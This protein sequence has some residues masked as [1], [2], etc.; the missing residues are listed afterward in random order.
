MT[1]CAL[2]NCTQV[3]L[4]AV[5]KR[6]EMAAE[7]QTETVELSKEVRRRRHSSFPV[8]LERCLLCLVV[9]CG[10]LFR[11]AAQAIL[12]LPDNVRAGIHLCDAWTGEHALLALK[13]SVSG[14]HAEENLAVAPI[15]N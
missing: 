11:C 2:T 5:E 8:V 6:K 10:Q 7:Q 9:L 1:A 14:P 12:L 3:Q 4:R 13:L 15:L